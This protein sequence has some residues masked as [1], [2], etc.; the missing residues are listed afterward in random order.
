[1]DRRERR[2]VLRRRLVRNLAW[3]PGLDKVEAGRAK[4]EEAVEG[5]RG[6]RVAIEGVTALQPGQG[7]DDVGQRIAAEGE[8]HVVMLNAYRHAELRLQLADAG[9]AEI[10]GAGHRLF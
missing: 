5:R 2:K 1:V 6:Y 4:A 3:Q 7:V 8:Q 9:Y 10:G